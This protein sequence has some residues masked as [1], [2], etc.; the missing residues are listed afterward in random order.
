MQTFGGSE[1][2]HVRVK[3]VT[4]ASFEYQVEEWPGSGLA[5]ATETLNYLVI[6]AGTYDLG[7]DN[8]LVAGNAPAISDTFTPVT[9]GYTF[10]ATPVVFSQSQ[11]YNEAT[12]IVTRHQSVTTTGFSLRVQEANYY[13]VHA[14]E[15]VGYIV[16][17]V[18][19]NS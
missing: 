13:A 14:T 5:H 9:W 2:A 16:I 3:N 18:G 12:P 4:S 10:P 17:G 8:K 11:S 1:A 19:V 7:S 6:E 15:N